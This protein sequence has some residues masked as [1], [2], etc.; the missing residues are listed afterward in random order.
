MTILH[1]NTLNVNDFVEDVGWVFEHSPWVARRA[2][3]HRPFASAL[4]TRRKSALTSR[5]GRTLAMLCHR[6]TRTFFQRVA[7]PAPSVTRT[8]RFCGAPLR[9]SRRL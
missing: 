7:F 5:A 4:R 6:R 1:L 3:K 9:R 8:V 2:W